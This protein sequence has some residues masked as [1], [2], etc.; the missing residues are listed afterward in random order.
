MDG[1]DDPTHQSRTVWVGELDNWVTDDFLRQMF[2]PHSAYVSLS[3]SC[4][5]Q[6]GRFAV[7]GECGFGA[8]ELRLF[9]F[10][11]SFLSE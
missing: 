4:G 6:L 7:F 11:R 9:T 3:H 1:M 5:V 10:L 2:L 8:S